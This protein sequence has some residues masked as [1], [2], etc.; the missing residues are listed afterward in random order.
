MIAPAS[1]VA[2]IPSPLSRRH[3]LSRVLP[4]AAGLACAL[5]FSSPVF[6]APFDGSWSV[7]IVTRS[8]ACGQSYRYGVT[9]SNGRVFGAGAAN[10][11]GRV[12]QNGSVSVSVSGPQGRAHGSG[13]LSRNSGGGS[14]SGSG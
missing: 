5:S 14:W 8:G 3:A 9:I 10:V 6:A 7:L 4:L 13:K 11:V 1:V 12:S 2:L